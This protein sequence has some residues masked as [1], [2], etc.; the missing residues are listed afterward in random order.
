MLSGVWNPHSEMRAYRWIR[1]HLLF[2]ILSRIGR[3]YVVSTTYVV[4]FFLLT[5]IFCRPVAKTRFTPFY[6]SPGLFLFSSLPVHTVYRSECE[7]AIFF[8]TFIPYIDEFSFLRPFVSLFWLKTSCLF[9]VAVAKNSSAQFSRHTQTA[10]TTGL[11]VQ[12]GNR[13]Q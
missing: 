12:F 5:P 11:D 7:N 9:L 13:S 10:F 1:T 4:H 2:A 8:F 6:T 3:F